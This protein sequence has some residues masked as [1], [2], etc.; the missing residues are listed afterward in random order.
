MF[1]NN[2]NNN[3][4]NIISYLHIEK[5]SITGD[6]HFDM[7]SINVLKARCL[8]LMFRFD[9]YCFYLVTIVHLFCFSILDMLN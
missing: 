7:T 5:N 2:N 3:N 6:T 4:N 1:N 9:G 8:V